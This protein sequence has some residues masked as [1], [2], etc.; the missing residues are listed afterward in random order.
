MS[1]PQEAQIWWLPENILAMI[2]IGIAVLALAQPWLIALWKRFVKR[3]SVL[4]FKT[5]EIEVGFSAYGPTLGLH[6]TMI[7]TDRNQFVHKVI[8]NVVRKKDGASHTLEWAFF[9]G[10]QVPSA[11]P[12]NVTFELASGYLLTTS[13]PHRYNIFFSDF[14]V[15]EEL[16][17]ALRRVSESWERFS[18]SQKTVPETASSPTVSNETENIDSVYREF[19]KTSESYTVFDEV[20]R[21]CYWEPGE[22]SL[23]LIVQTALPAREFVQAWDFQL[24]TEDNERLL[25]NAVSILSSAC[26]GQSFEWNFANTKYLEAKS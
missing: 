11:Q 5:G 3:G 17:A 10:Y 16:H 1:M 25:L 8:A 18:D 13:Q 12:Q 23:R 14:P 9:R 2:S 19:T 20:R 4:A 6:G 26:T 15:R 21:L 7:A 22:Y 24:T